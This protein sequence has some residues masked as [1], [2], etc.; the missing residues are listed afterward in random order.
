M[1]GYILSWGGIAMFD[2]I[3]DSAR[4]AL[5]L[6][7]GIYIESNKVITIE[8]CERIV[9]YNDIFIQLLSGGLIIRVWGHDLRAC[10][11]RT[12]GLVVRGSITQI[13]F[14]ERRGR[15]DDKAEKKIEDKR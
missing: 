1:L 5:F 10:G 3:A 11:Y 9:E 2:K 15:S 7:A 6:N 4:D 12:D 8:N 14:E 13:E